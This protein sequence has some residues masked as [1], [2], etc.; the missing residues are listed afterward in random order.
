VRI[1]V[2]LNDIAY[3]WKRGH[4]LRVAISTTYWPMIWPA[5]EPV[6]LRLTTGRSV[7]ELPVRGRR[8]LDRMVR[9][10]PPEQGPP[11]AKT[12]LEPPSSARLIERDVARDTV[13]IRAEEHEGRAIITDTGVEVGR[14]VTERL[15]IA[16][17]DPLS[18]ETEMGSV[19]S[20]AKGAWQTRVEGR[21]RLR[22][23]RTTWLLSADLDAWEGDAR[24]FTRHLEVP[25][26]RDLV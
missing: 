5:P 2:P 22:A 15:T 14:W 8:S 6:T 26:P 7:L 25:I 19:F 3:A 4:R 21:C 1:R 10:G 17:G 12:V 23:S 24:I 16:E 11:M 20:Y 18:A 13:T 9:F